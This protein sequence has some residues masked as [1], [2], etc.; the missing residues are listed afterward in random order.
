LALGFCRLQ[1]EL[2]TRQM[3]YSSHI[4]EAHFQSEAVAAANAAV[5]GNAD[6]ARDH[7]QQC[8]DTL[9]ESRKHFY[10][11]D[12]YLLDITLLA[13]PTVGPS[14]ESE[15]AL[16]R[17]TSILA[18]ATLLRELSAAHPQVWA[19]LL[20]AIDARAACVLGGDD[21][22]RELPLL[23]IETAL[24]SLLAGSDSYESLLGRRPQVYGRR[25]SGL[26]PGLVQLLVKLGYQGA[27]HFTLDDGRFPLGA[28]SKI[29]WEGLDSSVIDVF[30]R[31]PLDAARPE[32]FLGLSRSI[33]DAMDT[34]HVATVAFAH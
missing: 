2:L 12:V 20:A 3:R 34:D 17:P 1:M 14:L 19:K 23:P 33:A 8:F 16:A 22:E 29:R 31:V 30:A 5:A 24:C 15:L 25:R 11:V 7:L 10:P 32:S 9:Y 21:R 18:E 4:D 13:P 27:L 26:W 28:Q 6:G